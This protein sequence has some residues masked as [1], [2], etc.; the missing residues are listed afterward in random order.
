MEARNPHCS[1]AIA[2]GESRPLSSPSE[3]ADWLHCGDCGW[4]HYADHRM[5]PYGRSVTSA[6][7]YL[8]SNPK[9][10]RNPAA[11][12]IDWTPAPAP[13]CPGSTSGIPEQE[14]LNLLSSLPIQ[15]VMGILGICQ[16]S[17][18]AET[19]TL[20]DQNLDHQGGFPM[21][22]RTANVAECR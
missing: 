17:L 5:D 3:P 20:S 10:I 2:A 9:A 13:L 12:R 8:D 15:N 18:S 4:T 16:V 19:A 21:T 11:F 6:A 14:V 22:Q 7:A 1:P